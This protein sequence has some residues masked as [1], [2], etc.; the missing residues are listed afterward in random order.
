MTSNMIWNEGGLRVHGALANIAQSIIALTKKMLIAALSIAL[1]AC[2]FGGNPP[3]KSQD[4]NCG[5]SECFSQYIIVG[6]SIMD[7]SSEGE[8]TTTAALILLEENVSVVNIS[9]AGQTMAG[10]DG[11]GGAEKDGV[12]GTINYLTLHGDNNF[13]VP[14]TTAVIVQLAHNDWAHS[15]SEEDFFQSYVRFLESIDRPNNSVSV[16]CVVPVAA[17]WDYVDLRN[18]NDVT[19]EA[20][21]DVVRR[22]AGTGLC[23]IVETTDWFTQDDVSDPLIMTNGLHLAVGG[24]RKFKDHLMRD[25]GKYLQSH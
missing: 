12:G 8:L 9:M 15:T 21:R 4:P 10:T 18:S 22:V 14:R 7:I 16:F 2:S 11:I 5:T 19:Y 6:D 17:M 3:Y 23:N 13:L 25:M 24:H 1:A 20:F